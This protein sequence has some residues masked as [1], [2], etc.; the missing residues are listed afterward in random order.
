M[1]SSQLSSLAKIL[2][3]LGRRLCAASQNKLAFVVRNG[4]DTAKFLVYGGNI[5]V[6]MRASKEAKQYFLHCL[7]LVISKKLGLFLCR[8][9]VS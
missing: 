3:K 2:C 8:L 6:K 4:I 1:V 9:Y 5:T 7:G